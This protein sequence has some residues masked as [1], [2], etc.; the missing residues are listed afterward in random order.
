MI[1]LAPSRASNFLDDPVLRF[2]RH[3]RA[4]QKSPQLGRFAHRPRQN[5]PTASAA[6]SAAPCASAMSASALAY[7]RLADFNSASLPGSSQNYSISASCAAGVSCLASSDSAPSTASFAARAFNSRRAARS[8]ASISAFAATPI[9]CA[10]L[11]VDGADALALPPAASRFAVASKLR[12]FLSADSPACVSASRTCASA[13]AFAA[14]ALVIAELIAVGVSAE[15]TAGNFFANSQIKHA[16][17]D[18]EVDPLE[19]FGRAFRRRI[20]AFFRRVRAERDTAKSNNEA[21]TARSTDTYCRRCSPH[22][23][24]LAG[25][26]GTRRRLQHAPRNF[27]GKLRDSGF[28]FA[29]RRS[30]FA[31]DALFALR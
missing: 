16:R 5:P 25:A 31:G 29:A 11:C 19:N 6:G 13:A 4:C 21:S 9:F 3:G 28:N 7:W 8:A 20:A 12:D 27:G 2:P 24:S 22:R 26:A 10:S 15:T 30:N 1:L 18:R 17:D 23:A 14:V